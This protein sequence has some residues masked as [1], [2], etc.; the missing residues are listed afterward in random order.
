MRLSAS[1][2][3]SHSIARLPR[4][5]LVLGLAVASW[6]LVA[7]AWTGLSHLFGLVLATV[8]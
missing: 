8:Q 5:W 4:G 7:M 3:P 6:I 1:H 2:V